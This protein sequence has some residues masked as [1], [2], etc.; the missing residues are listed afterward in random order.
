MLVQFFYYGKNKE[1]E[2][3][4]DKNII[5]ANIDRKWNSLLA[6]E[7]KQNIRSV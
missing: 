3:I 4:V 2:I 1:K 5:Y 7:I 6:G